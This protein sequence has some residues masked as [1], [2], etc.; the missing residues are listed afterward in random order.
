MS[1]SP[2]STLLP[3]QQTTILLDGGL[4]TELERRGHDLSDRL[5]SARLLRDDPQAVA[6]VH[7][8]Y[9]LAGADIIATASY[10]ASLPGFLEAGLAQEQFERLLDVAMHVAR[11]QRDEFWQ[12]HATDTQR[13]Q[14]QVA[15]SIGPYGAY[16]ANGAE[17]T[18]DYRLTSLQLREFHELRWQRLAAGQPDVMLCETIPSMQE[19]RV[20]G[21]LAEETWLK[22]GIPTWIS[23]SCRDAMHLSDGTEL[24]TC[25]AA[26]ENL[27]GVQ[28]VGANCLSPSIV[29]DL[30]RHLRQCTDRVLMIYPN[31]GECWDAAGRKWTGEEEA[32]SFS[33]AAIEWRSLGATIIGGCCRTTPSHIRAVAQQ[34]ASLGRDAN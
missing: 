26:L 19:A 32:V 28:A 7:A 9:L 18:G 11:V 31:S 30:L 34:L 33:Q 20:L 16:L 2:P 6:S 14:P 10:Q 15:A 23:F 25:L 17:Y 8:D 22:S 24:A 3:S 4:G 29:S 13:K 27:D 5:W 1:T 21:Q 12:T